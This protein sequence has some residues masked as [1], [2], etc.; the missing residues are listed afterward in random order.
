MTHEQTD[1]SALMFDKKKAEE[2][3]RLL[4]ST[5]KCASGVN[6]MAA[7]GRGGKSI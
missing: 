2:Q 1:R 5:K 4:T 7:R 6:S 3:N